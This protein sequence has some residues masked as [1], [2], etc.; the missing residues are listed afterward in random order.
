MS[1]DE[2]K[3][4]EGDI[5]LNN[6]K[7]QLAERMARE[8]ADKGEVMSNYSNSQYEKF[9][10]QSISHIEESISNNLGEFNQNDPIE[11]E[12]LLQ[13]LNRKDKKNSK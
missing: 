6:Y 7:R 2:K 11:P 12:I 13:I 10:K 5:I 9:G 4:K 8:K 3:K 1:K